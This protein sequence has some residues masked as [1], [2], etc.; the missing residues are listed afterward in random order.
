LATS[1]RG[2]RVWPWTCVVRTTQQKMTTPVH[3]H[4][5]RK[6][7]RGLVVRRPWR[8]HLLPASNAERWSQDGEGKG[9]F[10]RRAGRVR[11]PHAGGCACR[12]GDGPRRNGSRRGRGPTGGWNGAV[13]ERRSH[14]AAGGSNGA[15]GSDR[16]RAQEGRPR[17]SAP[18]PRAPATPNPNFRPHPRLQTSH[19]E[20]V[21]KARALSLSPPRLSMLALLRYIFEAA[22]AQGHNAEWI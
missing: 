8:C 3:G 18:R 11:S 4:N 14:G 17:R 7:P 16:G 19:D 15:S 12:A 13:G 5:T 6:G 22:P 2:V 10:L 20:E 1:A 21:G 9:G